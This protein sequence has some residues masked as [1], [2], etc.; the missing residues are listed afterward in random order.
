MTP[1]EHV[2]LPGGIAVYRWSLGKHAVNAY[3]VQ[4]S[5]R[6]AYVIDPGAGADVLIEHCRTNEVVIAGVLLTHAHWDHVGGAEAVS[7]AA[8]L[9]VTVHPADVKLLKQAPL[10]ALR[11]DGERIEPVARVQVVDGGH[12]LPL[13]ASV[14]GCI[15][16]APGHTAGG[17]VIRLGSA[18]FT[19]DTLLPGKAGRTDLPGGS[20]DALAATLAMLASEIGASNQVFPGHGPSWPGAAAVAFIQR[21][22]QGLLQ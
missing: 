13:S 21:R 12:P 8:D 5:D 22:H 16:H 19:G 2:E 9:P 7:R 10:Y 4:S 18:V 15:L 1:S 14:T 6:R 11:M 17:V 20:A 3:V